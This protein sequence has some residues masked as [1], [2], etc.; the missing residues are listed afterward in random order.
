MTNKLCYKIELLYNKYSPF[1]IALCIF[2]SNICDYFELH[3]NSEGYV[4]VPSLLTSGHMYISRKNF[5]LCRFHRCFV[6]YVVFNVFV[7]IIRDN[8]LKF[9][10]F[11]GLC[12]DLCIAFIFGSFAIFYYY[13]DSTRC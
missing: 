5:K 8:I 11:Y 3:W 12:F 4:F 1:I 13:K 10:G 9:G 2:I 6:N 7:Y